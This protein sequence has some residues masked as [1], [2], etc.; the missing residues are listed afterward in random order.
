MSSKSSGNFD[1]KTVAVF[2]HKRYRVENKL[3]QGAFG[4]VYKV[5]NLDNGT[6]AAVKVMDLSKMDESS[7]KKF[8][9]REIQTMIKSNHENIIKVY[10]IFKASQKMFIFM[11]FAGLHKVL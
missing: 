1:Q 10:D 7:K 9:P 3:G 11:E 2:T 8:L 4:V 6:L 5:T